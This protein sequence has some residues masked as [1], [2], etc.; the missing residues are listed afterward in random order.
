MSVPISK[1]MILTVLTAISACGTRPPFMPLASAAAPINIT[2]TSN[3]TW[4]NTDG[5]YTFNDGLDFTFDGSKESDNLEGGIFV[6]SQKNNE[7]RILHA[8]GDLRITHKNGPA[9]YRV[10][11]CGAYIQ[12]TKIESKNITPT[13]VYFEGDTIHLT[14]TFDADDPSQFGDNS[15]YGLYV[16]GSHSSPSESEYD[17]TAIFNNKNTY[18]T[19]S[20]DS[21]TKPTK[22]G[23]VAN[24]LRVNYSSKAEFKSNVY[25]TTSLNEYSNMNGSAVSVDVGKI[26]FS[27]EET[28]LNATSK[29][30]VGNGKSI[31]GV[32]AQ[33]LYTSGKIAA[34]PYEQVQFNSPTTGIFVTG[35][36]KPMVFGIYTQIADVN[37]TDKVKNLTIAAKATGESGYNNRSVTGLY[38]WNHGTINIQAENTTIMTDSND[39]SIPW[40]KNS[41]L[42]VAANGHI[43][44]DGSQLDIAS[45]SDADDVIAVY[46]TG[47]HSIISPKDDTVTLTK[48]NTI[49]LNADKMT[50]RA[51]GKN[52][53]PSYAVYAFGIDDTA[54]IN[55][56]SDETGKDQGKTLN[57]NGNVYA[58]GGNNKNAEALINMNFTNA[59]SRFHGWSSYKN[60]SASTGTLNFTFS[61]GAL[62]EMTKNSKVTNLV[63]KNDGIVDMRADG[64]DY[65]WIY[66]DTLSGQGGTF[67][68]DIDVR[69]MEAD[70]VY[71]GRNFTGN[72]SLDIYQK[73]GY[74]PEENTTEGNGLVLA[75]VNGDGT[76]TA[77]DRE[78]SLFY[79]R[80]ELQSKESE[81][82]GYETDWYLNR[83]YH[84]EPEEKPTPTVEETAS[85]HGL[86]Y[87]TWRTEI[88]KLLQ[89][90]GELRHNGEKETGIWAR[91]KGGELGLN[92]KYGFENKYRHYELGYDEITKKK[93]DVT[94]YQGV[95]FSYL[96]G[97]GS[98]H[99][100]T[101]GSHG[102]ALSFYSTDIRNKGHYLD[103]VF[104]VG[105]Y[106][107]D[108]T[109]Y[110]E[111]GEKIRG[112]FANTGVALSAEY[113]RKKS[114]SS[115]GWY[116]EPQTQLSLGYFGGDK[117]TTSNGVNV[118]QDGI[119][120]AIGRIGFNFG[121]DLGEKSK[122]YF[123]ANWYHDFAG[124]GGITM[125]SP[126]GRVHIDEDF[127]D[128]WFMYGIGTA[129][130][131]GKDSHFYCD[132]ER[133]TGS[134]FHTNW[135]WNVGMRFN[136]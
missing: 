50:L 45:H 75:T 9:S 60:G 110:A 121:K 56:N 120:S 41:A 113:G 36:G 3:T 82:E 6:Q 132:V 42:T 112:D 35:E 62:W 125:T 114:L 17:A 130:Q 63:M 58:L 59:D 1:S 109:A 135:Q 38:A 101:G 54:T 40:Y 70:R 81:E 37:F 98:Y 21:K 123:K 129:F 80:Y 74:V 90:M 39:S 18:L 77:K 124:N 86:V 89:R 97:D 46:A 51:T 15:P 7:H 8:K 66:A 116:I 19:A 32:N 133:S 104:K 96:D 67:K 87:Y 4:R 10:G 91:V 23:A 84:V 33:G 103:L 12:G 2:D 115:D 108:Y 24:A 55:I 53:T 43:K 68:E 93:E 102:G 47:D 52:D 13:Y 27:G 28:Q 111:E 57:V 20:Y 5:A 127:S 107:T 30:T 79:T 117:Y 72:Q 134:G 105:H 14:G 22:P 29:K 126:E 44:I 136:F 48:G 119:R 78:G 83:V 71:V 85:S 92:G 34:S 64:N 99:R 69:S 131:M 94:R 25:A 65:S 106:N 26:I 31:Y 76:F 95:S 88:D 128:T 61:N 49:D 16:R 11:A 73:D 122:V 100:G 118:D